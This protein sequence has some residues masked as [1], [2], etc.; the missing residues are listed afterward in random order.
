M[1]CI[2][3]QMISLGKFPNGDDQG[4]LCCQKIEMRI[5]GNQIENEGLALG[6]TEREKLDTSYRGCH[7]VMLYS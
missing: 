6:W 5:C 2:R 7:P 3:M 1:L 4:T